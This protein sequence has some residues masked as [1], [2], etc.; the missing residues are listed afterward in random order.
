MI[1]CDLN[2]RRTFSLFVLNFLY[3]KNSAFVLEV[4]DV[5]KTSDIMIQI[6]VKMNTCSTPVNNQQNVG[7][8]QIR[9]MDILIPEVV[10]LVSVSDKHQNRRY[11]ESS[12]VNLHSFVN[13]QTLHSAIPHCE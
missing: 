4:E 10:K 9:E 3:K 6:V 8:Y 12:N 7:S 5:I 2:L 1:A 11:T 13:K